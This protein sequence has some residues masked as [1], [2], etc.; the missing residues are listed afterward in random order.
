[1]AKDQSKIRI[2]RLDTIG[3]VITELGRVYRQMRRGQLDTL[4]GSRL[5][6]VLTAMRQ[7]M[8]EEE[9][10]RRIRA[11]EEHD[12]TNDRDATVTA[13]APAPLGNGANGHDDVRIGSPSGPDHGNRREG[14][15]P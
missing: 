5:V 4:D 8:Q 12:A 9:F 7:A 10:E 2:G 15:R 13:G 11:L 14:R 6:N 3:C 1:V